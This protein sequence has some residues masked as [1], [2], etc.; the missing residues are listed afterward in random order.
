MN[1]LRKGL[2]TCLLLVALAATAMGQTVSRVEYYWDTDPGRGYGTSITGWTAANQVNINTT[3]ST[4]GLSAGIHTLGIRSRSSHGV[5]SSVGLHR[6]VVGQQVSRIEY[7]YDIDPGFGQGRTYATTATEGTVTISDAQLSAVGISDGYHRL[8]LRARAGTNGMWSPTY[9]QQVLVNGR[10]VVQVEYFYDTVPAYGEGIQYTAFTPGTTVTVNNAQLSAAGV[11]D[12]YHRLG[13]RAKAG[14]PN[15]WWS[16]VYWQDVLVNGAGVAQ[17]EYFYDEVPAYGA[18]IQYTA[19]TPGAT[20][21]IDNAQLSAAG[22]SD[23]YHRLGLRAKAGGPNGRWS[24]VYWHD[25]LVNGAGV[26]QVEYFYDEVPAY[27]QGIQYTAFSAGT[28]VTVNNAQLSATG[29]SDGYHRLGLR[30]KASGPNGQWSPVY[31]QQVLVNGAGITQVEYYWDDAHPAYGAATPLT[32]FTPGSLV[33]VNAAQISTAGLATGVHRLALRA[34][35]GNGQW[36]ATYFHEVFVGQGADY[37]EYYWDSDPGYGQA[38]P[39]AFTPGEEVLVNLSDI[40]VPTSD[41]LHS[42]CIRARAGKMWSPTY[43]KTYC[44]APTPMFSLIGS[45]TVCQG[46]QIIILD[47]TEGASELTQYSWDMQSDGTVDDNTVGDLTYTYTQPG[48]YELTLGVGNDATCQNTYSKTIMVRSTQSPTVSIARDRNNVCAGDEVRFVATTQRAADYRPQLEWYRNDSLMDGLTADTIYLSDLRQGDRIRAKVRVYNPCATADSAVSN[49]LTMTVYSLPEV[50]MRKRRFVFTDETAFTLASRFQATPTGGTYTINGR[51]AT[52]FNPARNAKGHYEISYTYANERGCS[53]TVT[54]T[55]ELR[56]RVEYAVTGQSDDAAHG[57]VEGSGQYTIGDTA[58]LTALPSTSY[59]FSHW[60]DGDSANP[61]KVEVLSDTTL[62]AYW[63]RLCR[64]TVIVEEATAC[65]SYA[66]R[67]ATYTSSGDTATRTFASL[68]GCDSSYVLHLTVLHSTV[69]EVQATA[70]DSY[71]WNG[72]TITESGEYTHATTNA[73][74]CDSTATLTL[75]VNHSGQGVETLTACD[76][77]TWKGTTYTTSGSYTYDTLTAKGC[78]STVTLALTVNHSGAGSET[79]TACD[80]YTWKGT[81][82]A[83]SGSYSY[84]TLTTKGC[85][86]TVTLALTIRRSSSG[87][88]TVTACDSYTWHGTE[89]TASTNEATY[90]SANAAGCDSTTT[91]HLTVNYSGQGVET[92]TTCDE[93]LWKGTAYTTSGSYTF[94][95]LTAKG[96]DSTVTLTLTVNHS[97]QGVMSVTACDEYMWKGTAYTASGSYS[98]DT[99]TTKGCDSTVTLQLTVNH[100]NTGTE[101][102]TACNSYVWHGT[103]YTASTSEATYTTTNAAGCDS[104]VTLHLTINHCAT[105]ELTVCDSYTWP[106]TG[107]TYTASGVYTDGTDTL[108]LTV[109]HSSTGTDV[110]SHCDSYTWVDGVTYTTNNSTATHLTENVYGC[111]ST[112]TLALTIRRSSTGSETVTACNSYTWHGT[113]Y[114]ASTDAATYTTTNAAGC[115]STVTLHLT[116]NHCSATEVAACDS[117]EWHG[118]TYNVSGTYVDGNDTLRLTISYSSAVTEVVTACDRYEWHGTEYVVSTTNPRYTTTNAAGCDSTVTLNLTIKRSTSVMETVTACDSY[119][120]HGTTYTEGGNGVGTYSTTNAVGCDSTVTLNLTLKHSSTGDTTVTACDQYTWGGVTYTTSGDV[121]LGT[122]MRNAAG[123]DSTLVLHLTVT[124][125]YSDTVSAVACD[126]WQGYTADTTLVERYT[127]VAGCDSISTILV[128]INHSVETTIVDSAAG[129]YT[130]NGEVYAESGTYT[131]TGST[132]DGCDSTVTLVLTIDSTGNS[133]IR[134]ADDIVVRVYPNPTTG[135]V[136]L[137]ADDV[138]RVEVYDQNGRMVRRFEETNVVELYGLSSGSYTLK[139][140]MRRGTTLKRVI[141][142]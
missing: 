79:A 27:G 105:T 110:Q 111:D 14:G 112:V 99:L 50:T 57:S 32:G 73:A 81:V 136:S 137:D 9:W 2:S 52:L 60:G 35:T 18:G 121:T 29:I 22:I 122:N 116:I 74:G 21:S 107:V 106:L 6:V 87:A 129:E 114:T 10:G 141:L 124:P 139:I 97:G 61:R 54:D 8:G 34:R 127:T 42:L 135:T 41:G 66:W 118:T 43:V 134:T 25:V 133:G 83:A 19:F 115:D 72:E 7:F 20:V 55:F 101:N 104:T 5:W 71:L 1:T 48:V 39:I 4:A 80:S 100:S 64:D 23:G 123:C 75:T 138:Q 30:A 24:P 70:C 103:E 120:W 69:G 82:Y 76:E 93:Y 113:E 102:V 130:W 88:E 89:Y 78:D 16:P 28:T 40:A 109:N 140:E 68:Y 37:A 65:D 119:T 132:E 128:T 45:D 56:E 84:D 47:E 13:L 108:V 94:D 96:C 142:R 77:Y 92:M 31:W 46:E 131:W 44:N 63:E 90:T 85:D 58:T 86:S 62:T 33:T 95:T 53:V 117:Y 26:V 125:S 11:T 51:T 17:V 3:I 12:G 38:T 15:G 98:F 36:S 67:G 59:V 91:L 126:S 49:Q